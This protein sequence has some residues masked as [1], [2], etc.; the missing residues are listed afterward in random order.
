[1]TPA[2]LIG[3]P[4]LVRHLPPPEADPTR[5][6]GVLNEALL[7]FAGMYHASNRL[8]MLFDMRL[9]DQIR[10]D[11]AAI[12]VL[13]GLRSFRCQIGEPNQPYSAPVVL[14]WR[15]AASSPGVAFG[16]IGGWEIQCDATE[17]WFCTGSVPGL[18]AAQPD[19]TSGD[20]AAILQELAALDSPFASRAFSYRNADD[21]F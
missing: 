16:L 19:F 6:D 9:A 7:V 12:L 13:S 11:N 2:D 17:A 10:G 3:S 15:V 1:M 14:G 18:A 20:P 4:D 8:A 5:R 21:V